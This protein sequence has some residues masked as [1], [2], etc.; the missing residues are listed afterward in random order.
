MPGDPTCRCVDFAHV[1]FGLCQDVG[2]GMLPCLAHFFAIG[3]ANLKT[4]WSLLM[5]DVAS[6]F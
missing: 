5:G 2:A 1:L 6:C 3:H 4:S